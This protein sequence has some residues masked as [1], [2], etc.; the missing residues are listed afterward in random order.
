MIRPAT[1]R[2]RP[3]TGILLLGGMIATLLL[4]ALLFVAPALGF[5]APEQAVA[6][7]FLDIPQVVGGVFTSNPA[8]AS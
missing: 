7:P 4:S 3:A 5:P 2:H 1:L 8:A 6:S